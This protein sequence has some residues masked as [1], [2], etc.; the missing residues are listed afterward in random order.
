VRKQTIAAFENG[1]RTVRGTSLM[2]L[3]GA[4]VSQ[5][6]SFVTDEEGVGVRRR[7]TL[8]ELEAWEAERF[9]REESARQAPST[10][11]MTP[12]QCRA[13]RGLLNW[14]LGKL[15]MT[16]GIGTT[17]LGEFEAGKRTLQPRHLLAAQSALEAAGVEFTS[18]RGPGVRLVGRAVAELTGSREGGV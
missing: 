10:I 12:A 8:D 2:R 9:E 16:A 6:I 14:T 15:A 1:Q 4:L 3:R 17:S 11:E 18:E 13:A 7:R 5:G